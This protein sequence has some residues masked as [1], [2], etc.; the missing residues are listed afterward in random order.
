M[1]KYLKIDGCKGA[2]AP[3]SSPRMVVALMALAI[4][5]GGCGYAL[6]SG[7]IPDLVRDPRKLLTKEEQQEAIEDLTEKKEA[8]QAA[9]AK[10]G[11]KSK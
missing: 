1:H 4:G 6:P 9:I 7:Q 5:L 3:V 11:E 10:Q 2:S 8:Q